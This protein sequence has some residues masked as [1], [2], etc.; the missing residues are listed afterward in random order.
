MV[1][2]RRFQSD[3]ILML[4]GLI[5]KRLISYKCDPFRFSN[6]VYQKIGFQIE[7]NA[8]LLTNEI[9]T[10]PYFGVTEDICDF[11][12]TNVQNQDICSGLAGVAQITMP[13]D[14]LIT[15]ISILNESRL[16]YAAGT[17]V[18]EY[19]FVRGI[20]ITVE[21][22]REYS[23]EKSDDFSEEIIIRRGNHLL[24]QFSPIEQGVDAETGMDFQVTRAIQTIL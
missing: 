1:V 20:V 11:N 22:G 18:D 3:V 9:T 14:A 17:L 2:D 6:M 10:Q 21:D 16:M 12:F 5:G 24:D 19:H 13:V 8:Y 23:F 7:G 4:R 15:Q